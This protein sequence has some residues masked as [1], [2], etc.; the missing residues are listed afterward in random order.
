MRAERSDARMR[1]PTQGERSDPPAHLKFPTQAGHS[2]VH[3]LVQSSA[4]P[5]WIPEEGASTVSGGSDGV[6]NRGA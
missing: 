3:P 2:W 6:M 5:G 1:R 4:G